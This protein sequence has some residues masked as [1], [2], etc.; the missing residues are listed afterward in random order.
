MDRDGQ[1]EMEWTVERDK[2]ERRTEFSLSMLKSI[3]DIGTAPLPK[4][5]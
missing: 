2:E 5:K 4:G 3:S 1:R